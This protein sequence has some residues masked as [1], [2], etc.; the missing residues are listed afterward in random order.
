MYIVFHRVNIA[1]VFA[2]LEFSCIENRLLYSALGLRCALKCGS[3]DD[4]RAIAS[5]GCFC[6]RSFEICSVDPR[7]VWWI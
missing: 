2:Q 4:G 3:D 7:S 5:F 1:A 6:G